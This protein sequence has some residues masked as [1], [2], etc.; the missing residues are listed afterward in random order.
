MPTINNV[1]LQPLYN[2]DYKIGY[3]SAFSHKNEKA[4]PGYYAVKLNDDNIQVELTTTARVGF[5]RYHYP[6]CNMKNIIL[7]LNH[8]DKVLDSYFHVLDS[9]TVVGYRR[10]QAWAQNQIV[11]FAIKFSEPIKMFGYSSNDTVLY[12]ETFIVTEVH[13]K[14]LKAAFGFDPANSDQVMAKV[15]I[16]QTSIDGA[17]KNLDTELP[18]WNF[19]K[20]KAD[21][22]AAWNKEL[23]KIEVS[24]K[25]EEQSD[26]AKAT[27]DEK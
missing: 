5:H 14:N 23:S 25:D 1:V 16:S 15:A 24:T 4:S 22:Q 8:R 2:G 3:A 12:N 27:S 11:Y 17:M 10:S 18:G 19:E 20:V 21:A 9:Y 26:S 6:K 13:G 7:D